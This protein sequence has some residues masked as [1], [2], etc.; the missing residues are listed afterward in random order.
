MANQETT[1]TI[2]DSQVEEHIFGTSDSNDP[3]AEVE[4]SQEAAPLSPRNNVVAAVPAQPQKEE[5]D[6]VRF[7]YWQ[8]EA[9]KRQNRITNLEDTNQKLQDQLLSKFESP[10]VA[11]GQQQAPVQVKEEEQSFPPPPDKPS[12]PQGFDRTDAYSDPSSESAQYLDNVET[13][14]D[15]MDEYN[16]LH[17][18]YQGAVLQADRAE[19]KE[20]EET[21]ATGRRQA[22]EA[23]AR[24]SELRESLRK[25]YD[26]APEAIDDFI[27]KMSDPSSVTVENLWKLYQLDHGGMNR[28]APVEQR[29]TEP[30]DEFKQVRNAQSIPSPM[31]V[32]PSSNR[33]QV[34]S[35]EDRIMDDMLRDYKAQNP[36]D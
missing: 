35:S 24:D 31:G 12:K 22:E 25:D 23:A 15:S 1:Q 10:P 33:E 3:F 11:Q 16:R 20:A 36:F 29:Q 32:M 8:S 4:E 9:D 2:T 27:Q 18:E 34:G 7:E 5:N 28:A 17:V 14:R 19:M 30:S 21:R 26:A 13:W 6:D